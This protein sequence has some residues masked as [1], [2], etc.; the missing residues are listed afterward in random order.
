MRPKDCARR[1]NL[2]IRDSRDCPSRT[3]STEGPAQCKATTSVPDSASLK[4]SV[5][6]TS[7]PVLTRVVG[8]SGINVW[9]DH[10]PIAGGGPS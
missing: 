2:A 9:S 6:R 3:E 5:S 7:E 4:P 10:Q 8:D 1:G